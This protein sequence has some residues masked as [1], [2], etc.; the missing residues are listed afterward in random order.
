MTLL[1]SKD[2]RLGAFFVTLISAGNAIFALSVYVCL[3][4]LVPLWYPQYICFSVIVW[5]VLVAHY[6]DNLLYLIRIIVFGVVGL[7]P[8][9]A[10]YFDSYYAFRAVFSQTL[11]I[12]FLILLLSNVALFACHCGFLVAERIGYKSK[13]A[14]NYHGKT[15]ITLVFVLGCTAAFFIG[16]S[17]G[18]LLFQAAYASAEQEKQSLAISNLT[19]VARF[20]LFS[21]IFYY[22]CYERRFGASSLY[23]R[24]LVIFLAI[25]L[26][27]WNEFLRG[28]RMDPLTF[29]LGAFVLVRTYKNGGL[30]VR[31]R[32]GVMLFFVFIVFQVW[33]YLRFVLST[34]IDMDQLY[35]AVML[36]PKLATDGTAVL[37]MQGTINNLILTLS[38][39]I[40]AVQSGI[41]ELWGGRSYL[42]YIL[43]TPPAFLFPERPQSLAWLPDKWFGSGTTA[44]GYLEL[45]EAYLNFGFVGALIVPFLVSFVLSYAYNLFKHNRYSLFHSVLFFSILCV[46]LRGNLYQTFVFYKAF[47]S[48]VV[49]YLLILCVR[50]CARKASKGQEPKYLVAFNDG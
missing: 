3:E 2:R 16:V 14:I 24:F 18:E 28:A 12:S 39:T 23:I 22:F 49:I 13:E 42:E 45:S 36:K 40:H 48:G 27:V 17:R 19:V 38:S 11:G 50:F 47:I 1:W 10:L 6:L 43:R 41:T 44:G 4:S 34:G 35:S 37:F 33:G 31:F 8:I 21:L 26:I 25:Y 5:L 9:T 46:Y 20:C 29:L 32:T 7:I 15:T 30:G